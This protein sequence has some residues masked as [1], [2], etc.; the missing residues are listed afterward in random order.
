VVQTERR[1]RVGASVWAAP[2][3][4]APRLLDFG[5]GIDPAS[6]ALSGSTVSWTDA[7][8]QLTAPMP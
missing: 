1:Q 4:G 6:L 8:K 7:G 3:E 2:R 5:T